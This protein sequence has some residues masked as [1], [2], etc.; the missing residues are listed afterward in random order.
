MSKMI[1]VACPSCGKVLKVRRLECAAC[2]TVVEGDFDLSPVARL[3]PEENQ[4]VRVFIKC[5][6][7]LKDVA[8]HYGVSYPTVRN[9]LDAII[10]RISVPDA[11]LSEDEPKE[12]SA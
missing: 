2:G 7:S 1:P 10:E 9:R 5:S 4:F 12:P 6:G 3:T 8:R 11:S